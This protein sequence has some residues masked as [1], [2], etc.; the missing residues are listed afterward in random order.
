M[1][2]VKNALEKIQGINYLAAS[3]DRE[4]PD[5][6]A[7]TA[8]KTPNYWQ[9]PCTHI[10]HP[11]ASENEIKELRNG[12]NQDIS[13]ELIA[14]LQVTNGAELFRVHYYLDEAL[15]YRIPRYKILNCTE[16]FHVNKDLLEQYR[17]YAEY[18]KTLRDKIETLKL[19]YLVFCDVGDGNF[20]AFNLS[21]IPFQPIFYYNHEYGPYPYA[22]NILSQEGYP[23]VANSLQDWLERLIQTNGRDGLGGQFIPF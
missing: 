1:N 19:D 12:L 7:T 10:Y 14:L 4:L 17:S 22:E 21:L 20:L 6:I 2:T 16:L 13:W 5:I 9:I 18:D 15:G 8:E 23:L 3:L 11:P